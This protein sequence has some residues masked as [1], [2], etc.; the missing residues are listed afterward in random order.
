MAVL[1]IEP[2][3]FIFRGSESVD[4]RSPSVYVPDGL[5]VDLPHLTE[6]T[7]LD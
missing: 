1:N 3:G 7:K 2:G 6:G 5:C 4:D